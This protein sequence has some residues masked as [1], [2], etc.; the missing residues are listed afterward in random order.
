MV[1][2]GCW[3]VLVVVYNAPSPRSWLIP[4]SPRWAITVFLFWWPLL[5]QG[6]SLA[7]RTRVGL[8]SLLHTARLSG[9]MSSGV[10]GTGGHII[11]W[12]VY[13]SMV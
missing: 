3:I 11:P 12:G 8:G 2:L 7:C 4:N 10:L 5:S 13:F 9:S 1:V 6:N